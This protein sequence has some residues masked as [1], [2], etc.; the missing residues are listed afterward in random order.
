MT[1]IGTMWRTVRHLKGRQILGRLRF[2]LWQP[3]PELSAAPPQRV[4]AGHWI[5]PAMRKPS[6]VSPAWFHLLN[7]DHDLDSRGWDD[8]SVEKLLLYHLHYF[9]DLNACDVPDRQTA[10]RALVSRWIADNPPAHGTGWEPYPVSLRV[11]NWIKWFL[12]GAIPEPVWV[13]SLAVQT[14]WLRQR[15]ELHLLGN[16]LFANAKALVF[17]G[18]YFDGAEG[19][20]WLRDGVEIIEHELPEQVLT[21]GGQFERS[22]MYHALAF[23]DV[24]EL[25]NLIRTHAPAPRPLGRLEVMLRNS[26]SRMLHW[27]RC[28]VHPDSSLGRFNDSA[29]GIAAGLSELERYAAQLGIDAPR[30]SNDAIT[31]LSAS[32]YIRA[33]RGSALALLDVAPVGP[34]YLPAHAHADTLSFELSIGRQ[35]VIVNGG[36]SCYGNSAQRRFERSTAAQSTVE[37]AGFDSSEVWSDFRVG[38]RARPS[39]ATIIDWEIC[40]SHDGYHFLPGRPEHRRRWHLGVGEL[41]VDD[42][43]SPGRPIA[44]ARYI[45]APGLSLIALP[46]G[47]W[48]VMRYDTL[49]AIVEVTQGQASAVTASYAPEFGLRMSVDCLAVTLVNGCASTRWTWDDD[50]H[51]GQYRKR[52]E[53][54]R[55]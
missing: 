55:P 52:D 47:H 2:R 20:Q 35:R 22:P 43:V 51:R 6:L 41:I 31:Y 44:V 10:Q 36:T 8:A 38:R 26:A 24:L 25:L 54:S 16:H 14:R 4:H 42:R 46:A 49:V 15:L 45:L 48:H 1:G 19:N 7:V 50:A 11:V 29:D 32:G 17:A 33:A 53:A 34:D 23:E 30:P 5:K 18:A 3:A 12:S 21:D 9:D 27:M 28:M 37:V 40:C 13:N 39:P